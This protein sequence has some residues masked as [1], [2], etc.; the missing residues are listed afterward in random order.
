MAT[1]SGDGCE[2]RASSSFNDWGELMS[3]FIGLG[4]THYPSLLGL[5]GNMAWLLQWTL[6]DPDIPASAK[7]PEN[8]SDA[9]RSEWGDDQGKSAAAVHRAQLMDGF[10]HVRQALEDFAPDVVVM[11]GDDQYENF[12]EDLIPPFAVLAYTDMEIKPWQAMKRR[13]GDNLW[14]E[15]VD[16][17]FP[18]RGAQEIGR[19][20]ASKLIDRGFDMPY[21]YEPRHQEGLSHSFLNALLLLDIDRKGFAYPVLP[22]SVNCYGERVVSHKGTISRF[23][24]RDKIPDPPS[25]SPSRCMDLGAAVA[26]ILLESPW[27]AAI[28]ASSSWSHAF[29]T[30]HTWRLHPDHEADVALFESLTKGDFAFWRT[31][32]RSELERAGQHEMLNWFC[33]AGALEHQDVRPD[34][35]TLVSTDVFNSNK[36]FAVLPPVGAEPDRTTVAAT[37]SSP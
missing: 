7:D 35:A 14:G 5:D 16:T 10:N 27:R 30:D 29:L 31:R 12:K 24:D 17:V 32:S 21:A 3:E 26:E 8:W 13:R 28:I 2:P 1:R 36:V 22:I 9:M 25:P 11:F 19:Y 18:V 34:W 33:L 37:T 6:E 15:S 4:L 23:R 20:L